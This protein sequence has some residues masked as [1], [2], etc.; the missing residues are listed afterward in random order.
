MKIAVWHNLPSGGGKRALHDQVRGLLARGH[1]IEVWCPETSDSRYL[2]LS[3]LVPEH[4]L[5]LPQPKSSSLLPRSFRINITERLASLRA[6]EAHAREAAAQIERSG[7]DLAL[8]HP[9]L[10]TFAPYIGRFLSIPKVLYLQEPNRPLYEAHPRLHWVAPESGSVVRTLLDLAYLQVRRIEA[11]EEAT[12]VHAYDKVLSNS[13]FSRESL[14]R[15]YGV[16]SDVC[17][18]GVNTERLPLADI[19]REPFAIGLG[20]FTKEKGLDFV[21]EALGKV[22]ASI[23]P[24]LIWV[25]NSAWGSSYK[26]EMLKLAQERGVV[27]EPREGISDAELTGLLQKASVMVYASRL[28]PFGYAPLEAACCGTPVVAVQEGGMRESLVDGVTGLVVPRTH[29]AVAGAVASLLSNPERA[30]SLGC[31][32]A[33]YVRQHWSLE[34]ATDRL[35]A[36]LARVSPAG[37]TPPPAS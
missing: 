22:S 17:Y 36:A 19:P 15:S 27:F 35:E 23:R 28:E 4:R 6:I 9:C 21:I 20:A 14:L 1:T 11:R 12:N 16:E 34:A 10:R 8:I 2:P 26:E 33:S 25:G 18:L 24:K 13:Y 37:H 7:F 32:A 30:R 3:E 29:E 31:T 5:P